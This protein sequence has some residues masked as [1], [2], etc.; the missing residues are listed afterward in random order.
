MLSTPCPCGT[1]E[2]YDDCC[3]PL[4]ANV[5]QAATPEQLM[6]SRYTAFVTG[7]ADHLRLEPAPYTP[8]QVSEMPAQLVAIHTDGTA[9]TTDRVRTTIQRAVPGAVP[10][11]G[12]EADAEAA[13][14]AV[15][16]AVAAVTIP[17]I[18]QR[19]PSIIATTVAPQPVA[20]EVP[21]P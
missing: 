11:L 21:L 8:A 18:G 5:A 6:R 14:A 13:A 20:A 16:D 12:S 3:G 10:W 17:T 9:A 2:S 19:P 4:L 15:R 7:D 1:G